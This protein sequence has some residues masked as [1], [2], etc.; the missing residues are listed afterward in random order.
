[1]FILILFEVVKHFSSLKTGALLFLQPTLAWQLNDHLSLQ[2]HVNIYLFI[3]CDCHICHDND[4]QI[5]HNSHIINVC[6][7]HVINS[8]SDSVL[9]EIVQA[10]IN[11][12]PNQADCE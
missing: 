6:V 4:H 10:W 5:R 11:A 7:K 3:S 12:F 1:M 2:E 9:E 8:F